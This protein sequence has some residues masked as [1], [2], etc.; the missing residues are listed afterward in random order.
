MPDGK[1]IHLKLPN[2]REQKGGWDRYHIA[3]DMLDKAPDDFDVEDCF[4]I[5]RTVS[6]EVCPTVV[7]MVYD[8]TDRAVYW[9]E[10]RDWDKREMRRW[11]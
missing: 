3:K 5:L 11:K 10:K 7:S 1:K 9:C 8:V 6:Q 4:E 2:D